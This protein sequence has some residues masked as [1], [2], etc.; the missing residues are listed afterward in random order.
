ME[1][2]KIKTHEVEDIF[3]TD[4][5]GLID[6]LKDEPITTFYDKSELGEST[7]EFWEFISKYPH[8]PYEMTLLVSDVPTYEIRPVKI[9]WSTETL[10]SSTLAAVNETM[11]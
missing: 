6:K 7:L 1:G 11:E 9:T 3:E 2:N 5:A 8:G 10:I 4:Y